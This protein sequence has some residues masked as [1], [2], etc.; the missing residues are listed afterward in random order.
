MA[1]REGEPVPPP[2]GPPDGSLHLPV[3]KHGG[4]A[5]ASLTRTRQPTAIKARFARPARPQ[6]RPPPRVRHRPPRMG[7]SPLW[8]RRGPPRTRNRPRRERDRPP[9][10]RGSPRRTRRGPPRTRDR[11]RRRPPRPSRLNGSPFGCPPRQVPRRRL[12]LRPPS[13]PRRL[14][15]ASGQ[16]PRPSTCSPGT[17]APTARTA[18]AGG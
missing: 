16:L 14:R 9:Q 10:T 15:P 13:P 3:R 6:H 2:G 8:T 5:A 1:P 18:P 11:P 7:R 17:P 4:P 12:R